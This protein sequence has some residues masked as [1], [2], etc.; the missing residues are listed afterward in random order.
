MPNEANDER[1]V[2]ISNVN[3]HGNHDLLISVGFQLL[4]QLLKLTNRMLLLDFYMTNDSNED[5]NHCNEM[6]VL[7]NIT[8]VIVKHKYENDFCFS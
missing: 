1:T 7:F 4:S 5:G 6:A 2:N 8:F 3:T